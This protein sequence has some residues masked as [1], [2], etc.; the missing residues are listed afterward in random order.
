MVLF[1][2]ETVALMAVT[3]VSAYSSHITNDSSK[4]FGGGCVSS[5]SDRPC[6]E[7]A[8]NGPGC[9]GSYTKITY[10]ETGNYTGTVERGV[11]WCA[12]CESTVN[13]VKF[14]EGCTSTAT[15]IF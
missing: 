2:L 4:T 7:V 12:A 10:S 11:A 15:A 8:N 5:T 6:S 14:S 13:K 1:N 3:I 9:S